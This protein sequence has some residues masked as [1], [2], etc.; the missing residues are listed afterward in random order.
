MVNY[1]SEDKM[2]DNVGES[3]TVIF[4]KN[5]VWLHKN[6]KALATKERLQNIQPW[7]G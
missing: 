4:P 3:K 6:R 1:Q 2:S 5:F 7:H